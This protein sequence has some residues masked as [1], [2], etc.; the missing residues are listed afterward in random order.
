[1][2]SALFKSVL[3]LYNTFYALC[4]FVQGLFV[5]THRPAQSVTGICNYDLTTAVVLNLGATAP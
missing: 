2:F 5:S 1:M 4:V 3:N